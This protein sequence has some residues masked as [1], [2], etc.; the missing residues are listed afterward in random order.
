MIQDIYAS[1]LP[2]I[3]RKIELATHVK[4]AVY[5]DGCYRSAK[6]GVGYEF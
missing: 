2:N 5:A 6:C 4:K 3:S 1:N